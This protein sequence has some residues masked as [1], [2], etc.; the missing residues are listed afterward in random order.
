MDNN[1]IELTP[2]PFNVKTSV[3]E[4]GGGAYSV[5]NGLIAF[6]N[7]SDHRIYLHNERNNTPAV[8]SEPGPYRYA[9]LSSVP[10][11]GIWG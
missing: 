6:A 9:D 4:Y 5:D 1:V 8:I 11:Q 3:H 2:N 10:S 7:Y